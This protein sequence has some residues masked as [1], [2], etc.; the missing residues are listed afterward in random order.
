M[1]NLNGRLRVGDLRVHGMMLGDVTA[2]L[3]ARDGRLRIEESVDRFYQGRLKGDARLRV[4]VNPPVLR[5]SQRAEGIQA[6][7]LLEDLIGEGVITGIGGFE[8]DL[9]AVGQ[10]EEALKRSLSGRTAIHFS[11]GSIKGFNL[12]LFIRQ[13][14][15]RLK[16]RPPP[17]PE[18]L[19]TDFTELRASADVRK[20]VFA[21]KDLYATSDFI[22]ASG[23]GSVDIVGERLDYRLEPRFVDPPK[24]RGI[25]EIEDIPVP[26]LI[27]GSFEQPD[28]R[29]DLAP[30]LRKVAG[31]ELK[32]ELENKGSGKLH[33]LE[34]RTGIK[35]LEQ[36]LRSL[37]NF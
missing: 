5:L 1:L 32:K 28:W 21:N 29:I 9:R 3:V 19:Q 11:M 25:K 27:T 12:D 7:P 16:G 37:F 13:A 36:G 2:K 26:I 22:H 6:G 23:N 4:D 14:E 30:V 31:R 8:A 20:G 34:E 17:P 24:G 15:A 35:G 33:E 10:S 18:P